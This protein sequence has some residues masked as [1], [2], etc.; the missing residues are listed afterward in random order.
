HLRLLRELAR[1]D[2]VSV[3]MVSGR[4]RESMEALFVEAP[5]VWLVAEHGGWLRGD[6]AW[7]STIP[8]E[9]GALDALAADF[10]EIA[11]AYKK[12]WVEQKTWS[13]CLH[14]RGVRPR[15]RTGILVQANAAFDARTRGRPGYEKLEG[16]GT[17]EVRPTAARKSAAVSWMR[18]KLGPGAR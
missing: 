10:E 9:P 1:S 13:V 2:G 8:A 7:Q 11:A 14:Y 17:L 6:G 15:E 4:T 5:G 12:A 18:E 16:A 3:A